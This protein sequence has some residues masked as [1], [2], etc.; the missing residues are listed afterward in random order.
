MKTPFPLLTEAWAW[1]FPPLPFAFPSFGTLR[2]LPASGRYSVFLWMWRWGQE[3]HKISPSV[4]D[5][6]IQG[7]A[8]SKTTLPLLHI[9]AINLNLYSHHCLNHSVRETPNVSCATSCCIPSTFLFLSSLWHLESLR[10]L[11]CSIGIL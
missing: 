5:I 10:S 7:F 4:P 6:W 9:I 2:H 11:N 3:F 8:F 1:S